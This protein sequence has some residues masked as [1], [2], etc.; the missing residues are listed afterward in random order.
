MKYY[1]N[2]EYILRHHMYKNEWTLKFHKIIS[3]V[4]LLDFFNINIW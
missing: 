2:F 4:S 3:Y 1:S